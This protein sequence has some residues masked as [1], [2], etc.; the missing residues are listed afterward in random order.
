MFLVVNL[1]IEYGV[2]IMEKL[3]KKNS[4]MLYSMVLIVVACFLLAGCSSS[5]PATSTGANNVNTVADNNAVVNTVVDNNTATGNQ[6][7][8]AGQN[9]PPAV[10]TSQKTFS[11]FYSFGKVASYSYLITA[12]D[13]NGNVT[14]ITTNYAISSDTV[15]GKDAWLQQSTMNTGSGTI[16][17]KMWLDK[18][19]NECIQIKSSMSFNGQTFD[20]PVQCPREGPNAA[21]TTSQQ[22]E[23]TY[24]DRESVNVAAGTFTADK[25][26]SQGASYWIAV[27]PTA[28]LPVK[29]TTGNTTMELVSYS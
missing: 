15:D 25:Y 11:D 2:I 20:T 19:T 6:Q 27:Q 10:D 16:I 24:I 4:Y 28:P 5:P 26:T 13:E 8:T 23:F 7:T 17:T 18:I 3:S 22:A 1:L 14:T 9:T 21:S 12:N 29:I